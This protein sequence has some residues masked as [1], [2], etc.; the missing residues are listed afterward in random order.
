MRQLAT[1]L[2]LSRLEVSIALNE[3]Q[4]QEKLILRRGIIE[5]P[6]LQIL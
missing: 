2:N 5:V 4:Q 1:E 6:A 3:L